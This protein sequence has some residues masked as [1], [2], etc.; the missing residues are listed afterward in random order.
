MSTAC[1]IIPRGCGG[2]VIW[3]MKCISN[4]ANWS[5]AISLFIL[6]LG[7]ASHMSLGEAS[8]LA[9]ETVFISPTTKLSATCFQKHPICYLWFNGAFLIMPQHLSAQ[10]HR[11]KN[12]FFR[13][14]CCFAWR[15][16]TPSSYFYSFRTSRRPTQ[17]L[18][19]CR[20][21]NSIQLNGYPRFV[22]LYLVWES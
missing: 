18:W 19:C 22:P 17:S 15:W 10:S 20:R 6:M 8:P 2:D 21:W 12:S 4:P 5:I 7:F 3:S 1:K 14:S 11:T 9:D 13:Q 16:W